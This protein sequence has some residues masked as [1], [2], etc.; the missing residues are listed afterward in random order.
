MQSLPNKIG[1]ANACCANRSGYFSLIS[2]GHYSSS[3]H[4]GQGGA[5]G[6]L[7]TREAALNTG[8]LVLTG[9]DWF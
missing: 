9:A 8:L 6:Q 1:A 2:S 5:S 4:Q 7:R 3:S